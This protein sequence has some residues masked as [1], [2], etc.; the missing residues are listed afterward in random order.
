MHNRIGA[1]EERGE[2][3]RVRGRARDVGHAEEGGRGDRAV[4][5]D[6]ACAEQG[7]EAAEGHVARI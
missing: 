5:A 2:H 3:V 1:A 6:E 4:R 7:D